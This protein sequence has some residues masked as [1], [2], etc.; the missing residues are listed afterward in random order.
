M[1]ERDERTEN[2]EKKLEG[3]LE[4]PRNEEKN[5][6]QGLKFN[7]EMV[8]GPLLPSPKA[9]K[10]IKKVVMIISGIIITSLLATLV[11]L[12]LLVSHRQYL[13]L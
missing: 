1:D 11:Y 8:G 3:G 6:G 13:L 5:L 12:A 2:L 10:P 7:S 9:E 4:L